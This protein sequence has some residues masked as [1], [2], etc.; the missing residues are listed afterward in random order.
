MIFPF[1]MFRTEVI[2]FVLLFFFSHGKLNSRIDYV[3]FSYL[4]IKLK[5]QHKGIQTKPLINRYQLKYWLRWVVANQKWDYRKE[6]VKKKSNEVYR[7]RTKNQ[8]NHIKRV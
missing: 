6:N 7:A 4:E 1:I 5:N 8:R 2:R 3:L